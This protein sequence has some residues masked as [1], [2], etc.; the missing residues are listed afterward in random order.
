M[1]KTKLHKRFYTVFFAA[2]LVAGCS[3]KNV[4][5]KLVTR[6]DEVEIPEGYNPP[7]VI[8]VPSEKAKTNSEGELYYDNEYGYRYWKN[9]N[10]QYYLDAK[11]ETQGIKP[12]LKQVKN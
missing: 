1:L 8:N 9:G 3:S 6:Q 2:V 5:T 4:A 12:K 7:Q 11:Y 10:G